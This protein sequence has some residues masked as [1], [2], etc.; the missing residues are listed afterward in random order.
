MIYPFFRPLLFALDPETAHDMA[1]ASLD[2][3]AKLGV[4]RR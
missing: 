2:V 1:F 3:A 4:V